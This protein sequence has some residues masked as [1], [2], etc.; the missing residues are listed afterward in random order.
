[1]SSFNA[2]LGGVRAG[3]APQPRRQNAFNEEMANDR[4]QVVPAF[5]A[6]QRAAKGAQTSRPQDSR[7]VFKGLE[8]GQREEVRADLTRKSRIVAALSALPAEQQAIGIQTYGKDFGIDAATL[9]QAA[10]DPSTALATFSSSLQEAEM[11]L[12][13]SRPEIRQNTHQ[14][15]NGRYS[16]P[17]NLGAAETPMTLAAQASDKQSAGADPNARTNSRPQTPVNMGNTSLNFGQ[18][19]GPVEAKGRQ[20]H[21]LDLNPPGYL[22]EYGLELHQLGWLGRANGRGEKSALVSALN[23]RD[24]RNLLRTLGASKSLSKALTGKAGKGDDYSL[25]RNLL[26]RHPIVMTVEKTLS[27]DIY[28][29][30]KSG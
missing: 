9:Q 22:N 17:R 12:E 10:A 5:V 20:S 23:K 25:T 7:N 8:T 3:Q 1:M 14:D 26:S 21:I 29:D 19:M 27:G 24:S 6:Q 18:S 11:M 4:S 30:D 2:F 28:S 15:N 13:Q 16:N